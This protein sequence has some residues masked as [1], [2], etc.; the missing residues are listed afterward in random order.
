[1]ALPEVFAVGAVQVRETLPPD[2]SVLPLSTGGFGVLLQ[3]SSS[4]SV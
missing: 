1:M 2:A 4:D 3:G